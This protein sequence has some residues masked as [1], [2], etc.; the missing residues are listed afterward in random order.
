MAVTLQELEKFRQFACQHIDA[1]ED[2]GSLQDLLDLWYVENPDPHQF[3]DDVLSLQAAIRDFDNGD[4][5]LP[6]DE[7]L[8]QVREL[9]EAE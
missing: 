3:S 4:P 6:F 5:G 7:H 8:R 1:G 2:T 9:I